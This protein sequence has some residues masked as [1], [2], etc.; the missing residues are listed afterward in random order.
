MDK[1][2]LDL[3]QQKLCDGD[4]FDEFSVPTDVIN[5]LGKIWIRKPHH[6]GG[7]AMSTNG[8]ILSNQKEDIIFYRKMI[9]R[10]KDIK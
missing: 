7:Q 10:N 1:R 6:Y 5:L 2:F 9:Y 8:A 4:S 3:P